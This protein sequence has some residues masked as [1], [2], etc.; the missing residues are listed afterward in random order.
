M[1]AQSQRPLSFALL[2]SVFLIGAVKSG[3]QGISELRVPPKG[4]K[5]VLAKFE[6][7]AR[8]GRRSTPDEI[9]HP[10]KYPRARVDSV[11]DDLERIALTADPQFIGS[12]AAASLTLAGSVDQA[13]PGAMNRLL[14]VYRRSSH[15]AVR[16]MIVGFMSDQKDRVP[17]IA[18]LKSVASEDPANEDFDGASSMAAEGLSQMGIEGRRALIDLRSKNL[19]RNG[20]TLG[21]VNWFLS[22]H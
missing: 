5:E 15:T 21:F 14:R 13:L 20:R 1:T 4:A 22:T 18:F 19:L 6:T 11:L 17:A 9:R 16:A 3:A 7:V 10:E 2:I 12:S 8:T